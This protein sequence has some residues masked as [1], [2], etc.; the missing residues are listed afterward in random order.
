MA[1]IQTET[2][3]TRKDDRAEDWRQR[4]TTTLNTKYCLRRA[5]QKIC[6]LTKATTNYKWWQVSYGSHAEIFKIF[7][8][9]CTELLPLTALWN[10]ARVLLDLISAAGR[11]RHS[12]LVGWWAI[13]TEVR[14]KKRKKKNS[15]SNVYTQSLLVAGSLEWM[16]CRYLMRLP[17]EHCHKLIRHMGFDKCIFISEF[18]IIN[19]EVKKINYYY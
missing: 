15:H 13:E 12:E 2:D 16:V 1:Q 17:S 10:A 9:L 6:V 11:E 14:N 7:A 19:Y 8:L 5:V 18:F 4:L 3:D